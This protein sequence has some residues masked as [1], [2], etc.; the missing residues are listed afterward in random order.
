M[1]TISVSNHTTTV[2]F[3]DT[4]LM[5]RA[6]FTMASS[7]Q[8]NTLR[9]DASA[10]SEPC[11]FSIVTSGNLAIVSMSAAVNSPSA[12]EASRALWNDTGMVAQLCA[13]WT[14]VLH[15]TG[16]TLDEAASSGSA[17]ATSARIT[18][19]TAT[20]DAGWPLVLRYSNIGQPSTRP[21]CAQ[22]AGR[23]CTSAVATS[24]PLSNSHPM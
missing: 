22:P 12:L 24:S 11:H 15:C 23:R 1:Y 6:A 17:V 19:S 7:S 13:G 2:V 9:L 16:G 10:A 14:Q 4:F 21:A 20:T 18:G 3:G 8:R 5:A